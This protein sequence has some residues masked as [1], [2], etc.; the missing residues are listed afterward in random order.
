M[1]SVSSLVNNEVRMYV[2]YSSISRMNMLIRKYQGSLLM[3]SVLH[4]KKLKLQNYL[5]HLLIQA[6]FKQVSGVTMDGRFIW[7]C[8]R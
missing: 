6:L 5:Q 3:I 1:R 2:S 8:V 4:L 7:M